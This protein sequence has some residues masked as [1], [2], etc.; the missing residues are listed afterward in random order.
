VTHLAVKDELL[1]A[2]TLRTAG[3]ASAGG[4][5]LGEC[6][7]TAARVAGTDLSSWYEEWT[8]SGEALLA[9]AERERA[10]GQL[11][12]ARH[13]FFRA[14]SYLRTAGV[15]LLAAP[16]E[17]RVRESNRRQSDAFR[18]G[19][20]L[21]ER[22]PEVI[23]IPFEATTLPGYFFPADDGSRPRATVILTGGYDGT[24]EE[25]YF[26][27]GA[28]A[29]E[30][31]YNVLCFDGP[32]QGSALL[33]QGLL[34]R[35]DWEHVIAAVIDV[36][37]ERPDVDPERIAVIG[38]SLGAHLAPRAASLDHRIAACV[39]DCGSFDLF[40]AATARMP[41]WLRKGFVTRRTLPT[42]ILAR[43]L[44]VMA[45]KPTLGWALRRGQLVHGASTPIE[46][47]EM[48]RDYSLRG[49]AEHIE[50]PTFVCNAEGDDIGASAPEL[51]A[52]L[53]CAKR[54]ETFRQSDG[55]G[56]HC[57]AGARARFHE[58]CFG[59]LDSVL[60]PVDVHLQAS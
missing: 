23:E 38:L 10:A 20:A 39:A 35:P 32:G 40:D 48:L 12:S 59:W 46:Y 37:T 1:D 34:L 43:I 42:A 27:T 3:A 57:E 24:A 25:L 36:V 29:L 18:N 30:R 9:V 7:A 16:L 2:Q 51:F 33:Q 41:G 55:A 8:A 19:A 60:H 4:A 5:E 53:T 28:A 52:E 50:C 58:S 47:L 56:D 11:V 49:R 54:F 17:G 15:M 44:R 6:L 13:A 26:L 21:L 14:S 45:T 22:P 31:G